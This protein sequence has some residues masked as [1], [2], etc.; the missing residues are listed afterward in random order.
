MSSISQFVRFVL[1]LLGSTRAVKSG[2][3][4]QD[5]AATLVATR[6][7]LARLRKQNKS[8]V[9][10]VELLYDNVAVA[11]RDRWTPAAAS[12]PKFLVFD[13][14]TVNA[15]INAVQALEVCE[16]VNGYQVIYGWNLAALPTE[17]EVGGQLDSIAR[18]MAVSAA[19][20]RAKIESPTSDEEKAA[21]LASRQDRL[22]A[23]K[24]A[25]KD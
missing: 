20:W 13:H 6:S 14:N 11:H 8:V 7:S 25:K 2:R 21:A 19:K 22:R 5:L 23:W 16:S 17:P 15:A 10:V 24:E 9:V 3:N 1:N 18:C 4:V 12:C